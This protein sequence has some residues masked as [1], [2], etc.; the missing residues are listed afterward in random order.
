VRNIGI[1]E[2]GEIILMME[3]W[4]GGDRSLQSP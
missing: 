2:V 1:Q 4:V 3:G